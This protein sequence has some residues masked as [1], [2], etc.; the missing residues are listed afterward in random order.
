MYIESVPNRNSPPCILLRESYRQGGKVRKRTLANLTHWPAEVV[1]ALRR[2]LR[3]D[4]GV[5]SLEQ[6]VEVV[7]SRPHGH[8]A[9]VLGALRRCGLERLLSARRCRERDAVVAMIV[10]RILDPRSKLATARGLNGETLSSSL[11]ELLGLQD[12]DADELY[13]ALDWLLQRQ[14]RIENALAK[15]HLVER[16]LVLYDVSTTYFD[17]RTCPLARLG[18]SHDGKPHRLQIVFGLLCDRHGCPIAVEVFPGNTSESKTFVAQIQ[19]VRQRFRVTRVVWVGDRGM[20]TQARIEQDLRGVQGLEWITTLRAPQVRALVH[21]GSLQLSL[22]DEQDLAEIS[23]PAY[24]GER[25]VACRNP[26]LAAERARKRDELL[27]AT[28]K[29]LDAIVEATG[30]PKRALRGQARIALRVGKVLG[31]HKMGKHF[32]LHIADDSFAY[33][34]DTEHIAQEAALD[35]IYIIRTSVPAQTLNAE[36]T[37]RA[38]KSL[39]HV[40]QAFRSC[41]SIDLH[42]RPIFHRLADRVRA[43]VLVCM[44]AYYVEWHMRR[45]LAP[46]LFD[47]DDPAA[48]DARRPSVVAPAQRSASAQRKARTKRT[49]DD[50]PVHSF[51]SLLADLATI[52]KNRI[53]P[54]VPGVPAFDKITLPTPLQARALELLGVRL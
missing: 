45:A 13:A 49:D 52:V 25:L 47:D 5:Q 17:G 40:E 16:T 37:V 10:A 24:P 32:D 43:H 34:L 20:I 36:D 4:T 2:A 51:Q 28:Q 46:L 42:V 26:F 35:G 21:S 39:S 29:Q 8:V 33:E 48:A 9:A 41:K 12:A 1:E 18:H 11:G 22:F 23:D 7:R 19:K 15:R 14:E 53:Q 6:A 30:R 27:Q 31:R 54:T 50:L 38:Y 3:D 44:L